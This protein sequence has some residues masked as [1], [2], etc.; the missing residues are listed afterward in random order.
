LSSNNSKTSTFTG[1]G[2]NYALSKNTALVARWESFKDDI[3]IIGTLQAS[4]AYTSTQ[5]TTST[6]NTRV[7]SMFG[8]HSAF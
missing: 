6:N 4:T 3:G 2:Y 5:G 1:A 7:R 8:I